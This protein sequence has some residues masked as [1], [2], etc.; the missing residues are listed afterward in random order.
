L[1]DWEKENK[2]MTI[3]TI[4]M[5]LLENYEESQSVTLRKLAMLRERVQEIVMLET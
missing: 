5:N 2:K 4:Q 3:Q 1:R